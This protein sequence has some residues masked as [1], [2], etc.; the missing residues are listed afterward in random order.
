[1]TKR[2][3]TPKGSTLQRLLYLAEAIAQDARSPHD[4]ARDLGIP[5]PSIHRLIRQLIDDGFAVVD[6]RG[7]IC[8]GPRLARLGNSLLGSGPQLA[9]RHSILTALSDDIGET[10][11]LSVPDGVE[12]LY[13]DRVQANWPVQLQL[14]VG[15]RVP[16]WCTS[17]GK[18]YLAS[19]PEDARGRML[20]R[21]QL[22]PLA[23]RTIVDLNQLESA[24]NEIAKS[25]I[26]TDEEEFADGMAAC[27]VPVLAD[28]G[29]FLA[30]LFTHALIARRSLASLLEHVP[31]MREAAAELAAI[32]NH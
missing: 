27:A 26:G 14:P 32:F 31:R 20:R 7:R 4:I 5:K 2:S 30:G 25:G 28:D 11:G 10:C 19:L 23:R 8:P 22:K 21:L 24:L 16:L 15:S 29:R 13:F 12:M 1:M 3:R 9:E 18:L 6:P 17:A